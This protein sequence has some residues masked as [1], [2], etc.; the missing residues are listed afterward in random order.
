M[1]NAVLTR[2]RL[3]WKLTRIFQVCRVMFVKLLG[4]SRKPLSFLFFLWNSCRADSG[5]FL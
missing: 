5:A 4:I 1:I 3:T 2:K